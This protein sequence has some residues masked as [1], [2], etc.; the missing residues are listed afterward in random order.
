MPL[1]M[2][3]QAWPPP[4]L[5]PALDKMGEWSAWWSGDTNAL[6]DQY[7]PGGR[8][9]I[10]RPSQYSGGV[11]G[12]VARMWWGRPAAHGEPP[13]KLHVPLGADI[14]RTSGRML[15]GEPITVTAS[16]EAT[17]AR[18]G[19]LFDQ[20]A[21]AKLRAAA[22]RQ[23]ALGGVYMRAVADPTL[24]DT[25][26]L[27]AV[28]P[29]A[30]LPEWRW[31]VLKAVTFWHIV[32]RDDDVVLRHLERHETGR[33]LHGL[34]QGDNGQLGRPI[35]LTEHPAT[36][37]LA[38]LVDADGGIATGHDRLTAAYIP[39][40]LPAPLWEDD[41]LLAPMGRSDL[42]GIEGVLDALD[43]TYSALMRDVR[44]A[45][46]RIVV[47][48]SM[49]DDQGPGRGARFDPDRELY[50]V[51]PGSMPK[52]VPLTV[53]QPDI[54]VE[55]L[56]ATAHELLTV[57]LRHAGYA[58]ITL[59]EVEGGQALTATEVKAKGQLS[60]MTLGEKRGFWTPALERDLIPA[61]AVVDAVAFG[62]PMPDLDGIGVEWP[63]SIAEDLS[64]LAGTVETL[65]R[66]ESASTERRVRIVNPDMTDAEVRK[67]V[68]A[69][70]GERET[71]TVAPF[72]DGFGDETDD[73]RGGP[74]ADEQDEQD[75][76]PDEDAPAA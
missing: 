76:E 49:L 27:D 52:D 23:A 20:H 55:K 30:A 70:L 57:A 66:A 62:R 43:E 56:T 26:W 54:R 65:N 35:P 14:C 58:L 34:Y 16:S 45:K 59:G 7:G 71:V 53:Y 1:P 8:G 33:I 37:G 42:D 18:L 17:S 25:A 50:A 22:E 6:A 24:R 69:I 67:E 15:F 73:L 31:D 39:N 9:P 21:Q 60:F 4:N 13:A 29:T 46:A 44:L 74:P 11:V 12:A 19:E 72:N 75:A 2:A 3:D 32:Y 5:R 48:D 36:I 41:P 38:E 10:A 47:G 28:S 40:M 51:V 68:D 61:L 64:S 63:D